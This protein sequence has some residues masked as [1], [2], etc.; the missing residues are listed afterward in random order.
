VTGKRF[1]ARVVRNLMPTHPAPASVPGRFREGERGIALLLVFLLLLILLPF[2][3]E[4][5][6]QVQYESRTAQNVT[7]QLMIENAIDGQFEIVLARLRYDY[8]EDPKIDTWQDSWNAS[9]IR[10]RTEQDTNV[11]LSTAVYDEQGKFNL[12]LLGQGTED[13]RKLNRD[14]LKRLL[15]EYRKDSSFALSDSEADA[16]ADRIFDYVNG[17]RDQSIPTMKTVDDRAIHVL[18]ELTFLEPVHDRKPETLLVDQRKEEDVA[19]GLQ[20]YVTVYGTGRLNLNTAD[21]RVLRAYFWHDPDVA[22]KIIQRREGSP[23]DSNTTSGTKSGTSSGTSSGSSSG[24]R[25]GSSSGSSSSS[26]TNA[27]GDESTG[28]PFTEVTQVT[29]IDG[30]TPDLLVANQVDLQSDFDV[31]SSFFSARILAVTE[32][33]RRDELFVVERVPP[34]QQGKEIDGFRFHLRQERTDALETLADESH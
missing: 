15:I 30:V 28:N 34:K 32:A 17:R 16:W 26:S 18:D 2:A 24:S 4:F 9:E 11:R 14:R 13:K 5:A 1:P 7:D 27:N 21:V 22:D 12:R 20:R 6:L 10:E 31:K 8:A 19:P 3:A 33:T 23:D 29:E 25:S